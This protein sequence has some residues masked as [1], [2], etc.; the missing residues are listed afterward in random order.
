MVPLSPRP[1]AQKL[2]EF[3][4]TTTA[5]SQ[6]WSS[7]EKINAVPIFLL[8]LRPRARFLTCASGSNQHER[9]SA[10]VWVLQRRRWHDHKYRGHQRYH[11]RHIYFEW[12]NHVLDE[13]SFNWHALRSFNH[14]FPGR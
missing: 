14:D 4:S 7:H 13:R 1:M 5:N 8:D 6:P 10:A 3:T 12:C 11:Q 2:I 9:D